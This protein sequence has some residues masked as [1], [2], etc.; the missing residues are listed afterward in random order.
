MVNIKS[1]LTSKEFQSTS[2]FKEFNVPDES[3]NTE[4]DA[5]AVN[6]LMASRGLPPLDPE[7]VAEYNKQMKQFGSGQVNSPF[8]T[9]QRIKEER[10]PMK[11]RLGS[12]AKQRIEMLCGISRRTRDVKIDDTVFVLKTLKGKEQR[13]AIKASSEFDNTVEAAYEVRKQ[14]L[15]RSIS[16]V[17]GADMEMFLNNSSIE[18]RLD[19]VEELDEM[20]LN[21]LYTE[22]LVLVRE[23]QDRFFPKNEQEMKEVV[24][25]IKK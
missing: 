20:V 12:A 2:K 25:D 18:A 8:Q 6:A 11:E 22:Y 10:Q 15:A 13:E 16:E 5:D 4:L 14:L 21:K 24:E 19:F 3:G 9:N 7:K 1:D 17:G 23:A